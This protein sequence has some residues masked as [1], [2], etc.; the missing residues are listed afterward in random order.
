MRSLVSAA[1]DRERDHLHIR[2][3]LHAHSVMP[4]KRGGAGWAIHGVRAQMRQESPAAPYR[5]RT[6]IERLISAVKRK[7]SARAPGRS[8]APQCLQA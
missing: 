2:Q 5:R 1:C 8:L 7:L 6:L 4:A 3:V